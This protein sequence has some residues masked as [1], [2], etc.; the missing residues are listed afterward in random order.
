M[1]TSIPRQFSGTSFSKSHI[2]AALSEAMARASAANLPFANE[3]EDPPAGE[4]VIW[5]TKNTGDPML[6]GILMVKWSDALGM[7]STLPFG[8]APGSDVNL[9]YPEHVQDKHSVTLP[10]APNGMFLW[11]I[12]PQTT[13]PG[14]LIFGID[15]RP[16]G[17]GYG[18]ADL[19]LMAKVT[20]AD[21]ASYTID[22]PDVVVPAAGWD[23]LSCPTF[24]L[25]SFLSG[26]KLDPTQFTEIELRAKSAGVANKCT[27]HVLCSAPATVTWSGATGPM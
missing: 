17:A 20:L 13:Q 3:P 27:L 9:L 18:V 5:V 16:V 11:T 7:V 22:L 21:G 10:A 26:Q 24:E 1:T 12:R 14:K 23:L 19:T 8:G 25:D 4:Y 2:G 6:D 15:N